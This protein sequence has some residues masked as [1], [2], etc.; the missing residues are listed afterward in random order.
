MRDFRSANI[1]YLT[2]P[3][4]ATTEEAGETLV[5]PDLPANRDLWAALGEIGSHLCTDWYGPDW[6]HGGARGPR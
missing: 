2:I 4:A 5:R 1:S 3:V 6:D